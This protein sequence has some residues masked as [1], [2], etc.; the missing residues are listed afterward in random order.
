MTSFHSRL[1]YTNFQ[2]SPHRFEE[3]LNPS[4]L[5]DTIFLSER[6]WTRGSG[7]QPRLTL[8]AQAIHDD[9]RRSPRSARAVKMATTDVA[10]GAITGSE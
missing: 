1:F 3:D 8:L 6:S 5:R 9:G 4:R 7:Q 2:R 10:S